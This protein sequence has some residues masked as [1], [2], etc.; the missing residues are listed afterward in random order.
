M[1]PV[2]INYNMSKVY[3][4]DIKNLAQKSIRYYHEPGNKRVFNPQIPLAID[5]LNEFR[6]FSN[7]KFYDTVC[8]EDQTYFVNG[9]AIMTHN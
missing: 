6:K 4:K 9:S 1:T 5:S 8:S 3:V 7:K 2:N